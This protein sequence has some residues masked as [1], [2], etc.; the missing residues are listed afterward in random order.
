[1]NEFKEIAKEFLTKSEVVYIT[2]DGV[3]FLDLTFATK[4]KDKYCLELFTFKKELKK[5]K[6]EPVKN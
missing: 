6:N 3:P 2:S 4:H 5:K 1:M